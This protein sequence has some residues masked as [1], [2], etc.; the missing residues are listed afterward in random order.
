[1]N[2]EY[3]NDRQGHGLRIIVDILGPTSDSH[4]ARITVGRPSDEILCHDIKLTT[5]DHSILFY[6][7]PGRVGDGQPLKL[8]SIPRY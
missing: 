6:F 1:M 3:R 4:H 5:D 7:Y 8:V 2:T